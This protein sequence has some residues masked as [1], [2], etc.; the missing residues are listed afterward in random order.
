MRLSESHSLPVPLADA[1][2]ALNDLQVL[3][4]CESLLEIGR[5]RRRAHALTAAP[6]ATP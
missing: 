2:A 3:P 1:W 6:R 5:H 4:G